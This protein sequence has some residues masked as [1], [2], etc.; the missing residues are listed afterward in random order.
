MV[1]YTHPQET[2]TSIFPS[3]SS[4]DLAKVWKPFRDCL[5]T[6][7]SPVPIIPPPRHHDLQKLLDTI[8]PWELSSSH[9][10]AFP[11]RPHR[12]SPE[13]PPHVFG[14]HPKCGGWYTSY[15]SP[16]LYLRTQSPFLSYLGPA[17]SCSSVKLSDRFSLAYL[18]VF[19]RDTRL[20][21]YHDLGK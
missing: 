4:L 10:E 9:H 2:A 19:H 5:G 12:F 13:E 11:Y 8:P 14:G 7:L 21:G 17:H 1:W 3:S 20:R 16:R 15:V 6:P 18:L